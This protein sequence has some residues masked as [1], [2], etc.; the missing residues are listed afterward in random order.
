MEFLINFTM[1]CLRHKD[2]D[3]VQIA[4]LIGQLHY[5][6]MTA[7]CS[8]AASELRAMHLRMLSSGDELQQVN[9]IKSLPDFT[10]HDSAAVARHVEDASLLLV[11][12]LCEQG[13]KVEKSVRL[14][15]LEAFVSV[16]PAFVRRL[17]ED[18]VL[19]EI[20]VSG[21]T[22]L[23]HQV[24][25]F[26]AKASGFG[27]WGLGFGVWSFGGTALK[28]QVVRP[29]NVRRGSRWQYVCVTACRRRCRCLD[30]GQG[31]GARS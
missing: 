28:H 30:G 31:L 24:Q 27:V 26:G 6:A 20:G 19:N 21:G 15:L 17:D 12:I 1:P 5:S 16:V 22:A 11:R 10:R 3:Q 23:K 4:R 29:G 13:G 2:S 9:A 18:I 25:G 8:D 7:G 14:H